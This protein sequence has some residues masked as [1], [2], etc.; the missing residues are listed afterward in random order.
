M[1]MCLF[2]PDILAVMM[3]M[4]IENYMLPD[5]LAEIMRMCNKI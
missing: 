1:R 4:C 2:R 5:S 3:R